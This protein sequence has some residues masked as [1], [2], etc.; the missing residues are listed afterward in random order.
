MALS[1]KQTVLTPTIY[2]PDY[3]L[4]YQLEMTLGVEP[5]GPNRFAR[6]LLINLGN[7]GRLKSM[8]LLWWRELMNQDGN[9]V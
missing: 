6:R 2:T 3:T 9:S 4:K 8:G 7:L 5:L 1:P